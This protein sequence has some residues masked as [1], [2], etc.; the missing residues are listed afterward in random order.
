MF[1]IPRGIHNSHAIPR[2]VRQATLDLKAEVIF[3]ALKGLAID[4]QNSAAIGIKF[5]GYGWRADSEK[6]FIWWNEI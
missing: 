1:R 6:R 2:Y 3:N 4:K 5:S